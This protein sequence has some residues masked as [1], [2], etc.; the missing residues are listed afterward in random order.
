[1]KKSEIKALQSIVTGCS[2]QESII[3]KAIAAADSFEVEVCLKALRGGRASFQSR[4]LLQGF[5]CRLSAA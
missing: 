1:M 5:V 2:F 3:N 4:M